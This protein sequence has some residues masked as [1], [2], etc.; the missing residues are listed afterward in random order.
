VLYN[1]LPLENLGEGEQ[2]RISLEI[3]MAANPNLKFMCI[4]HGEALDDKGL[5][6]VAEL[7]EKYDCDVWIT[8]VDSSGKV[9][10]VLEDGEVKARNEGD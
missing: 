7:A 3:G 8:K 10:I 9:G 5:K 2:I 4:R 1:G 6:L